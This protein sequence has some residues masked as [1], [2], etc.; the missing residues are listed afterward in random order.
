M[1]YECGHVCMH[2]YVCVCA[3][4]RNDQSLGY[5]VLA[6]FFHQI[7]V[8]LSILQSLCIFLEVLS[9]VLLVIF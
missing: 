5:C 4:D 8:C 3:R 7:H 1:C 6:S 2:V 9:L